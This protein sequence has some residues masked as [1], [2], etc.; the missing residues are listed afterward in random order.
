MFFKEKFILGKKDLKSCLN[1]GGSIIL[2]LN[3]RKE[4]AI[5]TN[6]FVNDQTEDVFYLQWHLSSENHQ[7][8]AI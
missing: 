6:D 8:N 7:I 1:F 3:K 4:L 5:L 2:S